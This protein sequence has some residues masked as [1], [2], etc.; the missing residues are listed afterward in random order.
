M[1]D[2]SGGP[3]WWQASDGKWYPPQPSAPPPPPGEAVAAPPTKKGMPGCLKWVLI[4]FGV[5]LVLGVGCTALIGG[6]ANEASKDIEEQK[7]DALDDA[8]LVACET[9]EAG[10]MAATVRITNDSSERSN[11]DVTVSYTSPDGSEQYATGDAYAQALEPGQ[12]RTEDA[13]SLEEPPGAFECEIKDVF[14]FTDE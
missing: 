13:Q 7:E 11:Y 5:A 12:S 1:S 8:E 14:R 2:Q 9:D 10:F 3:G 4:A 6:A